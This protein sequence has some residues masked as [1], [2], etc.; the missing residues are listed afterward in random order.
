M[1][2]VPM[3]G[4]TT[5]EA[6]NPWV[7]R[8]LTLLLAALAAGSATYWW[9]RWPASRGAPMLVSANTSALLPPIDSARIGQLLGAGV[10]A[11][12]AAP[13][14]AAPN[15]Q[16]LGIVADPRGRQARALIAFAGQVARPYG[17]GSEVA[18]GWYLRAVQSE[19]VQL[20]PG[21]SAAPSLT[22]TLPLPPRP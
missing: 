5:T 4:F 1:I 19:Q 18:D 2:I 3:Q 20:A 10:G 12:A 6:A 9:L 21:A 17:V 11:A 14:Q 13:V 15:F 22:L 16:L 7:I 8:L